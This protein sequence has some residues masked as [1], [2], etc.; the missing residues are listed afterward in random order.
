M[1]DIFTDLNGEIRLQG[2]FTG[3]GLGVSS[4]FTRTGDVT[5]VDG[6][7]YGIVAA[8]KTGAIAAS[9]YAGATASGAP[10][11]GT[12]A[13]GDFVIDQTGKIWICTVAGTPGTWVSI[14]TVTGVTAADTSVV[15]GGTAQAPTVRTNTLDVIATQHPPVA[16]VAMN[17]QRMTGLGA[18][19]AAT[20]SSTLAQTQRFPALVAS[21]LLPWQAGSAAVA[22]IS[23]GM[24]FI[25]VIVPQTGVLHDLSILVLNSSGNISLA[26]Y[27]T[28]DAVAGTLTRLA[29]SGAVACGS[30][31]V[32]QTYDPS[33]NVTAG[34]QILLA[35]TADNSTA[36]FLGATL[37]TGGS[38]ALPTSFVTT[39]AAPGVLVGQLAAANHPA[40]T[41]FLA[42]SIAVT[43]GSFSLIARIV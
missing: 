18:A 3:S 11:A 29:T 13:V 4:V 33:L 9:R 30:A 27:D 23:N 7:Y 26:I 5:A 34:Q 41:S 12:F 24:R 1:P 10:V 40:P 31:N 16:P 36:T 2:T 19:T 20:D 32:Y 37:G 43:A 14:G 38:V 21:P 35:L 42:S 8:A 28:G 39:A 17:A 6:D 22:C 15:V 25:R